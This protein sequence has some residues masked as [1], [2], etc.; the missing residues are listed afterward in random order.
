MSNP[1]GDVVELLVG[2]GLVLPS[3][4]GVALGGRDDALGGRDEGV[5]PDVEEGVDE[6]SRLLVCRDLVNVS[7]DVDE[8]AVRLLNCRPVNVREPG[9]RHTVRGHG[10]KL[11]HVL[12]A[13]VG[14]PP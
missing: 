13:A 2:S 7:L 9:E 8:I 1:V 12:L 5:P 14:P 11:H 4:R 3:T 10:A 6:V